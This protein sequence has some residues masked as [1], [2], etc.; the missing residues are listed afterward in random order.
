MA[1]EIEINTEDHVLLAT[2]DGMF[3]V[4][5]MRAVYEDSE[6]LASEYDDTVYCVLDLREVEID[7]PNILTLNQETKKHDATESHVQSMIV[8]RSRSIDRVRD[9]LVK[10]G[11]AIPV[12]DTL[13]A[14]MEAIDYGMFDV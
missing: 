12:F 11:K 4:K 1:V 3:T 10:S 9:V 5:D 14:A 2:F 6:A 8:G 13:E 7:F